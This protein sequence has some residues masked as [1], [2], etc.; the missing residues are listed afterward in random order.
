MDRKK[1]VKIC[2][3]FLNYYF[4]SSTSKPELDYDCKPFMNL[5]QAVWEDVC[6]SDYSDSDITYSTIE[7]HILRLK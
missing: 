4:N 6:S 1:A 3:N 2:N 5:V 7:D